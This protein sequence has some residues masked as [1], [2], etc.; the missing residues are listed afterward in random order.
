MERLLDGLY[1]MWSCMKKSLLTTIVECF[2]HLYGWTNCFWTMWTKGINVFEIQNQPNKNGIKYYVQSQAW[3]R[4]KVS[5]TIKKGASQAIGTVHL[6]YSITMI[7]GSTVAGLVYDKVEN[8]LPDFIL[9]L[10]ILVWKLFAGVFY[11]WNTTIISINYFLYHQIVS[12]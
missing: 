9:I 6:F 4:K 7:L 10:I 11:S 8:E 3:Y 5:N 2:P 12:K 1:G